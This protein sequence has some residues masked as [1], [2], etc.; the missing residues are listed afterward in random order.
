MKIIPNSFKVNRVNELLKS[1][2]NVDMY[3]L[4]HDIGKKNSKKLIIK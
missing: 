3:V 1:I 2:L 4:T